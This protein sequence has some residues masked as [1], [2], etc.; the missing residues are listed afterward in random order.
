[1]LKENGIEFLHRDPSKKPLSVS[2]LKALFKK[3]GLEARELLRN[4][5]K[6]YKEMGL[7][8]EEPQAELLTL[9][10]IHPGLMNRPIAVKGSRAIL[11]RPPE[12]VLDL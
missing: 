3:L 4:R 1:M 5:D 12:L 9:M 7:T 11:A 8:G 6:T 10:A 2:E